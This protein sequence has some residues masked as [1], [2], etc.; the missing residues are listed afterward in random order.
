[1]IPTDDTIELLMVH[2][3]DHEPV[4]PHGLD[5]EEPPADSG[6][7][8][9]EAEE[10]EEDDH[11][12][13]Y[14]LSEEANRNLLEKQRWGVLYPD[15]DA[16]R[17]KL[18]V[19]QPLI[20]HRQQQQGGHPVITKAVGPLEGFE[21]AMRWRRQHYER[22]IQFE[23]DLPR[24]VLLLGDF[25]ELPLELQQALG[26]RYNVG[27]L[28]FDDDQ[29]LEAYVDKVLAWETRPSEQRQAR[30]LFH[31]V[32]D[33]T[34]ATRL[35]HKFLV[36]P[37]MNM[38]KDQLDET[39]LASELL[40]LGSHTWPKT[41]DL[42]SAAR[43][44]ALSVL[45]SVSHGEGPPKG[46]WRSTNDREQRQGAMSFGKR[47]RLTAPDMAELDAFLPGGVWFM[48]AC[49]GAGTPDRSAYY[50]WLQSLKRQRK[51][52]GRVERVLEGLPGAGERPFVAALPKAALAHPNGPLAVMGHVDLAWSYSFLEFDSG[53]P[54]PQPA[55]YLSLMRSVLEGNRVGQSF[56]QLYEHFNTLNSQIADLY[57]E[58][59]AV[60][61][62]PA[63]AHLWMLRQD[64]SAYVLLGDPAARL[65]IAEEPEDDFSMA[66][67]MAGL[68]LAPMTNSAPATT[69][70]ALERAIGEVLTGAA[71]MDEAAAHA[72]LDASTF[73]E[74]F[75]RYTRA[76]REAVE[77]D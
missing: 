30:A 10:E 48:L 52:P 57:A 36:E 35:G 22:S 29:Q 73:E 16:G 23:D 15:T 55:R 61:E 27:R 75:V 74:R 2:A 6:D 5:G 46:G 42:L 45:L 69:T 31:T 56:R 49:Y 51:Y 59:K 26:T 28:A 43:D 38:A 50:P 4:L 44:P 13:S 39:F 21:Q 34:N 76:G 77:R 3:D 68:G 62:S 37:G 53:T 65:P 67:A 14:L 72:G 32:H 66:Q 25:W 11:H 40:E 71:S 19:I 12:P 47:S 54:E 64:I 20:D 58:N 9:G 63:L 1:M 7:E 33:K 60:T 70:D 8:L 17:R 18:Q 41:D 24:Y